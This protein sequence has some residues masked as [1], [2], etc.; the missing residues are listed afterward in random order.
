MNR[1][2]TRENDR[3]GGRF[4][5]MVVL[6]LIAVRAPKP[7]AASGAK[8]M[9]Q[10][11]DRAPRDGSS[12]PE[13][14]QARVQKEKGRYASFFFHGG[15]L[16]DTLHKKNGNHRKVISVFLVRRKGFEPPTFWFVAKHSIQL[17]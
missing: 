11:Q 14:S 1:A 17:S 4:S 6:I 13:L 12:N 7:R 5:F 16:S 2:F 8:R 15:S 3:R 10:C 9:A